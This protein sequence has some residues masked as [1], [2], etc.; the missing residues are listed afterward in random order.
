MPS[1]SYRAR[2]TQGILVTGEM[3]ATGAEQLK[4]YLSGQGLIPVMVRPSAQGRLFENLKK[5]FSQRVKP[6]DL[7]VMTRQFHTLFKA[8]MSMEMILGTLTRQVGDKKL[9]EVLQRI[10]SNISTGESLSKAFGHHTE[11]FGELYVTMLSAGEEA[12]LLEEVLGNLCQLLEKETQIKTSI[13]SATLYPKIVLTVLVFATVVIMT[14]VVPKFTSF[15]AHYKAELPLPTRILMT[16]SHVLRTS[17][18]LLG[19]VAFGGWI[20]YHRYE[21]TARGRVRIGKLAFRFPVFGPL[22]IK[23]AN[24]RFCH[25]LAALYRSGLP[26]TRCL[27]ITGNTIEN[28]AFIREMEALKEEVLGGK[29]LSESMAACHYFTPVVI[30]ATAVGEKAGSLDEMLEAMGA[31]YDLEVQHTIKNLTTLLEPFFLFMIF[32]LVT[33]FTL[34]IFLPIWNLSGVVLGK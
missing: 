34:A 4:L 21:R 26:I 18:W 5:L 8:G 27:E 25:I 7:L 17:W 33:L 16:T 28:G 6:T 10:H 11:L 2:D 12:G 9:K 14:F 1:F 30:D 23:V 19:I 22:N 29:T 20:L 31:H 3:E 32:G 13:K 24:S 15:Y